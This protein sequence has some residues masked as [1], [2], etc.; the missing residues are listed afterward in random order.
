[1]AE[2]L[3]RDQ[4]HV[5]V[6]GAVTDDVNQSVEMWRADATTK[7]LLVS[8]VVAGSQNGKIL[9]DGADTT[10]E[11]LAT[12]LVAGS[13]ITLT[14]LNPGGNET[15]EIASIG[16]TYY[17]VVQEDGVSV[18]QRPRLN[19]VNYFS[20]SDNAGNTSSDIDLNISAIEASL[21]LAN[22][23]GQINLATQVTGLLSSTNIDITDLE[24]N[25]NLSNIAGSID[26]STQVT[27][28]LGVANIDVVGI[29]NDATFL[30]S[31]IPN[32]DEKVKVAV[33]GITIVGDG[34]TSNPLVAT[35][36]GSGSGTA[37]VEIVSQT[38]HGFTTGQ[39]VRS[40]YVSGQYTLAQAD[41]GDN[42]AVIGIVSDVVDANTFKITKI[43]EMTLTTGFP[44]G[45]SLWLSATTPGLIT[46]IEP[47]VNGQ[48]AQPLGYVVATNAIDVK[49]QRGNDI[50]TINSTV[51]TVSSRLIGS[52]FQDFNGNQ[53]NSSGGGTNITYG[54][55]YPFV[56]ITSGTTTALTA[57][58]PGVVEF[59]GSGGSL[60]VGFDLVGLDASD[61]TFEGMFYFDAAL[62]STLNIILNSSFGGSLN[63]FQLSLNKVPSQYSV[64]GSTLASCTYLTGWNTF[65]V[66][67]DTA[68]TSASFYLNGTLV[69]SSLPVSQAGG[70]PAS[71]S[72][73]YS[74]LDYLSINGAITR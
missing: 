17:S 29:A 23:G 72:G 45:D 33:D 34:T 10:Y 5:T 19:F 48:V 11:Y 74:K 25:L 68:G 54:G 44:I 64:N 60:E 58:H 36:G 32:L 53:I 18:T 12:K 15:L 28:T 69:G 70:A 9:V 39:A 2:Q 38:S 21:D 35:G 20:V 52:Y 40:S 56:T 59:S 13:G 49:I 7:R 30:T 6:Q 71:P 63:Y 3:K 62:P 65:K 50:G 57:N 55:L 8:A 4:N 42:S 46:N 66:L 67:Y 61:F 22:I 26:L 41:T 73:N 47:T 27:G 16:S 24:S 1:M 31:L 51:G 37:I 43:G 14:V